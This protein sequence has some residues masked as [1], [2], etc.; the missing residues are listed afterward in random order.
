MKKMLICC[1]ALCLTLLLF[2]GTALA[3]DMQVTL[4]NPTSV[5]VEKIDKNGDVAFKITKSDAE[6]G[7]LY[8]IMIQEGKSADESPKPTKDN[9]YYL[10]VEEATA[11]GW[12]AYPKD[13]NPE[14]SYV[15]YLSDYSGS[16]NGAAKGVATITKAEDNP[17]GDPGDIL[18]GDVNGDG[19]VKRNDRIIL[20][21]YLAELNDPN[22]EY[23]PGKKFNVV[24]ANADVNADG[25]VK[26]NDRILLTRYLAKTPGYETLP[27]S[28]K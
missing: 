3:A 16:N 19:Q 24:L 22:S 10:N 1:G 25:E 4:T 15:I 18:Y 27:Y 8:L 17:G 2:C 23:G 11:A 14:S 20:T 13:L 12:E 21:H 9:L 26:R 5:Q 28:S 7:Q 6:S